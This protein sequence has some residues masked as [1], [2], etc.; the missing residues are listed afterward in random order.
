MYR[1]SRY[2]RQSDRPARLWTRLSLHVYQTV[3]AIGKL[4]HVYIY[5]HETSNTVQLEIFTVAYHTLLHII[6]AYLTISLFI[7]LSLST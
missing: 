7:L 3:V 4:K 5:S 2:T 1:G 6:I